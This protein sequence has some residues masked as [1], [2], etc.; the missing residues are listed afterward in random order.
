L[1]DQSG[2]INLTAA[3]GGRV[4]HPRYP[5]STRANRG[6]MNGWLGLCA[7]VFGIEKDLVLIQIPCAPDCSCTVPAYVQRVTARPIC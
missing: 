4:D 3:P 7:I 2:P 6:G 1:F 5:N